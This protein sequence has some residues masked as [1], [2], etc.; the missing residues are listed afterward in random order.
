MKS[1]VKLIKAEK[2][3]YFLHDGEETAGTTICVHNVHK[4]P[5]REREGKSGEPMK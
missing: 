4:R 2:N 5:E 3:F 1:H